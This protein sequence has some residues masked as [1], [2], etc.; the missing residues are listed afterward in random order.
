MNILM[1]ASEASPYMATSNV[2][3]V[4]TELGMELCR[5]GHETRI[6]IPYYKNLLL[7]SRPQ[8]I[9]NDIRVPFGDFEHQAIVWRIDI[10]FHSRYRLPVYLIE[11]PFFFDREKY[12][13]YFDDSE[14]FVFF[15]RTVLE[16]LIHPEFE[17]QSWRPDVIHGH[18]WIAGMI[19]IWL[20]HTYKSNKE[21]TNIPFVY[22]LHNT[23]F[24]GITGCSILHAA[25]LGDLGIFESLGESSKKIN[26]MA[27]GI[28]AADAVNTDSPRHAA[29][30]VDHGLVPS[31]T[32]ASRNRG[33]EIIGILNGIDY[34]FFNPAFDDDIPCKFD[35]YRLEG[36]LENKVALQKECGLE[37]NPEAL[38][39]GY[40]GRL[41]VNKGMGLVE[42]VM[43]K[44]LM[45]DEIQFVIQGIGGDNRYLEGLK[46]FM[47]KFPRRF[48]I[49]LNFDSTFSRRIFA[50]VDIFLMPSRT[51]P[52]GLR[53]I[54]AMH[55]GA[56]PLV[57]KTGGLA[58]TVFSWDS[59][60]LKGKGFLFQNFEPDHFLEAIH[61]A[62]NLYK[63]EPK[64]WRGLQRHNMGVNF[65][66]EKSAK[67]YQ[68]LYSRVMSRSD[69]RN[70]LPTGKAIESDHGDLLAQAILKANEIQ[71]TSSLKK[72][73]NQIAFCIRKMMK[74]DAVLI[75]ITDETN[76]QRLIMEACSVSNDKKSASRELNSKQKLY[77]IYQ[78]QGNRSW[79]NFYRLGPGDVPHPFRFGYLGSELARWYRWTEQLSL[80]IDTRNHF[81]GQLD[82][83]SCDSKHRFN[84][85]DI[86]ALKA[87]SNTIAV[88]LENKLVEKR[89]NG[90]LAANREMA[91][92]QT[93]DG[94]KRIVLRYAKEH[95]HSNRGILNQDSNKVYSMDSSGRITSS[96]AKPVHTKE[97]MGM[98]GSNSI[99]A[100]IENDNG[101][102]FGHIKVNKKNYKSFSFE[103]QIFLDN[104]AYHSANFIRAAQD[105]EDL[106]KNRVE[107]LRKLSE[108]LVG[109]VEF[110]KLLQ[111]VVTTI[112]E[113][114]QTEAASLY[115]VNE[116]SGK[117]EIKAAAGYHKPLL[118]HKA[119]YE[120]GE[121]TTGWIAQKEE[122]FKAD[123]LDQL[124]EKTPWKGKHRGLQEEREPN[125]FLGIPLKVKDRITNKDRVSGVLK[126]EDRDPNQTTKT[127]FTDED[128][129]LGQMMANVIATVIENT[130]ISD[131][132]LRE[133]NANLKEL[134]TAM[135]GDL[136]MSELLPRILESIAKVLKAQAA[137][138]YLI[139][140][141]T[142][143]LE[144]RA[145]AGYHKPLLEFGASYAIGEGTTGWIAETGKTFKA[146]SLED[147]HKVTSWKGKHKNIQGGREP[148]A[149]LGIPLKYKDRLSGKD[150]VIGVLK[151]EDREG[152]QTPHSVFTDEDMLLGEMMANVI[153]TVIQNTHLSDT[154]LKELNTNLQ[155]LSSAMVGDLKMTELMQRIVDTMAEVLEAE[156]ASLY[157]IDQ[158][159]Q[160]LEI[161]AAAGYH[162]PLLAHGA[163]YKIG[164]GTTGWISKTGEIFRA[165]SLEELHKKTP[166]MGKHKNLQSGRE[167]SVFLGIP[168]KVVDHLSKQEQV[169]GVLKLEDRKKKS[170]KTIFTDEDVRLGQMM[171]NVIA[172]VIQNSRLG[173]RRLE[174]YLGKVLS[175]SLPLTKK[176]MFTDLYRFFV[177]EQDKTVLKTLADILLSLFVNNPGIR[178]EQT[179]LLLRLDP[180]PDIFRIMEKRC[181]DKMLRQWLSTLYQL[182]Q[183][184]KTDPEKIDLEKIPE[185]LLIEQTWMIAKDQTDQEKI[186]GTKSPVDRVAAL[187]AESYGGKP[188]EI[189]Q[190]G[191]WVGFVLRNIFSNTIEIPVP[192]N[193]PFL[194][195]QGLKW[196]LRE[197]LESILSMQTLFRDKFNQN[198]SI[199][200]ATSFFPDEEWQAYS[201]ALRR[202]LQAHAIDLVFLSPRDIQ[203]LICSKEPQKFLL[204]RLLASVNLLMVSPYEITGPT[205]KNMFFGRE[206]ELRTISYH[207]ASKSYVIIGGRKIGK[208][209]IALRLFHMRSSDDRFHPIYHDC[210]ITGTHKEFFA[211]I[212]NKVPSTKQIRPSTFEEMIQS[213]PK[214]K[215]LVLLLDEADKLIPLDR[216]NGW[217]LFNSLR[218]IIHSGRVQVVLC[219]SQTLREAFRD[220]DAPLFNFADEILL[221]PLNFDAVRE[222]VIRPMN[223]LEIKLEN[224]ELIVETIWNFTSG[225]PN[226]IQCLCRRLIQRLNEKGARRIE[227]EDVSAV[228]EDPTFQREDFLEIYWNSATSLEVIIT[229]LMVGD[230]S[231]RTMTDMQE[232]LANRYEIHPTAKEID[233]ALQRLVDLRSILKRSRDRYEFALK[234]FPQ[235]LTGTMTVSDM[236]KTH[237]EKYMEDKLH[238]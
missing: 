107:D 25:N 5:Q 169:L 65:S 227:R 35:R 66:W 139:N 31:L 118:K 34:S 129:R 143:K 79:E 57:M 46:R 36:R 111:Q 184:Y 140:E 218:A 189:D 20:R 125:A 121:G 53:Q 128:V 56:I 194:F 100:S 82:V 73:L 132:R 186:A 26:F 147:L 4:V 7:R 225:H 58:D 141:D 92:S 162:K 195:F 193:L 233:D 188:E 96:T 15:T 173:E 84:G 72:H 68:K 86:D 219:G 130:H 59:E 19:P 152:K 74:A 11:N 6:A 44:L 155:K 200:V 103:D 205:S 114:L 89:V 75:W 95:T 16:M 108:S 50:G 41:S 47:Q 62:A 182:F 209:S 115:L 199:I 165:G 211:A 90:L 145:A 157:L 113:V 174:I 187:I 71:T 206:N 119:T 156:A 179:R 64:K 28:L 52:G 183:H 63:T 39:L 30:I 180:S 17:K 24:P 112:S 208:S 85:K 14:R 146:D 2:G 69:K 137:S 127:V 48:T 32:D 201:I 203:F 3:N 192:K 124:H 54:I 226:V 197:E 9:I 234:A 1:V 38:L 168:F 231:I 204:S 117:L 221:G 40:I 83:F 230:D 22:T 235:V 154:R 104:L 94:V 88:N 29:E 98:R 185:A 159:T 232:A 215:I 222:L 144:I 23:L 122:L 97:K 134:S 101:E 116:D 123:S 93:L 138:L 217:I 172:T 150:Q 181:E 160:Q 238:E 224:E 153:A 175:Y 212:V 51:E 196:E 61:S 110:D 10:D 78:E 120:I 170:T 210:S 87:V 27:R 216:K 77:Y 158:N 228:I 176:S 207:E 37:I 151:L 177:K 190:T 105:R 49:F 12:F 133:L 70:P 8:P 164:E 202:E 191:R 142:K 102:T 91:L 149:F 161:K 126:L 13:G 214:K 163:S 136:E 60:N 99:S 55:Y 167:P 220:P 76:S 67:E 237:L 213:F 178:E 131:T 45:N 42:E 171:A 109:G 236:L 148:N 135:V 198:V 81:L 166:W 21:L 229:L 18:D 43:D 33:A 223:Q 106:D 80:P